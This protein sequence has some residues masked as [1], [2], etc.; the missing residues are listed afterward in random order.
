[1]YSNVSVRPVVCPN[2]IGRYFYACNTIEN[3]NRMQKYGPELEKY[4]FTHSGYFR[5]ANTV[6]LGTGIKQRKLLFC[7][8]ILEG[9]VYK[10]KSTRE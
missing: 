2:F 5:L 10:K 9:L 6:S 3:Q 1:M 8:G 7:H 4:W